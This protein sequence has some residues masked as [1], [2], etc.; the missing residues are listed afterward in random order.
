MITAAPP[1]DSSLKDVY[2]EF[3][4]LAVMKCSGATK[5]SMSVCLFI[6][7]AGVLRR[8]LP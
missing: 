7:I 1:T 2:K 5:L 3:T 6:K 4:V 8:V